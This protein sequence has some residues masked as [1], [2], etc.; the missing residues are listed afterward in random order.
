MELPVLQQKS[1]VIINNCKKNISYYRSYYCQTHDP[2]FVTK[3]QSDIYTMRSQR[4]LYERYLRES[5]ELNDFLQKLTEVVSWLISS[6]SVRDICGNISI[7]T[8]FYILSVYFFCLENY[9][10][11]KQYV[12]SIF[13]FLSEYRCKGSLIYR[14]IDNSNPVDMYTGI[15][16]LILIYGLSE[17]PFPWNEFCTQY[18]I[19]ILNTI[20]KIN[21]NKS[22]PYNN[23]SLQK[24][25]TKHSSNI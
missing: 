20:H 11:M 2:S 21:T 19:D 15:L 13:P 3:A 25:I 9:D 4:I 23:I 22:T 12:E 6:P 18:A 14:I 16:D 10:V 7:L 8:L 17:C 1:E 24:G 5:D